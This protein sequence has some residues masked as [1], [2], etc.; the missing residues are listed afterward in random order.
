MQGLQ[1]WVALPDEA[2]HSEPRFEHHA[3]LLVL[4]DG[5]ATIPVLVGRFGSA[6]SPARV[7]T[8]LVA[9]EVVLPGPGSHRLSL[10]PAF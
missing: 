4:R 10:E 1:L 6:E 5:D 8:P 3:E 2:R 9:V 7:H